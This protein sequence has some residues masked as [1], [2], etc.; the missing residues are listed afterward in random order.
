[1]HSLYSSLTVP[2]LGTKVSAGLCHPG[3]WT[4]H[5]EYCLPTSAYGVIYTS[6]PHL[7]IAPRI[8]RCR[9][10]RKRVSAESNGAVTRRPA[11]LADNRWLQA[12]LL[13]SLLLPTLLD[14][15]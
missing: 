7:C 10:F 5:R 6:S 14:D 1:M 12:T 4:V 9:R 11:T 8:L 13:H 3:I 2:V 15:L